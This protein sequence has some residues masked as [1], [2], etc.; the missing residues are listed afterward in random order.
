MKRLALIIFIMLSLFIG[1]SSAIDVPPPPIDID[2]SNSNFEIIDPARFR[3]RQLLAPAYPGEYWVDF[4]WNQN[5]LLFESTNVGEETSSPPGK[6]KIA[7][8]SKS[9]YNYSSPIQAMHDLANWCGTPSESNPCGVKILPG[10]YDIG[11]NTLQMKSYV[12]IEGSGENVTK[13]TGN[14]SSGVVNGAGPAE[15]RL[16]TVEHRGG[17][18]RVIAMNGG[19]SLKMTNI[20]VNAKGGTLSTIGVSY[21]KA[22]STTATPPLKIK[23]ATVTA[24]GLI[25]ERIGV[26]NNYDRGQVII[27]HSVITGATNSIKTGK[28]TFVASTQLNGPVGG[29][30]TATCAGVYDDSFTFYDN[31]CP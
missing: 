10:V 30:G 6:P 18:N 13:I 16:L 28:T 21:Q 26:F 11:A 8:V 23:N 5:Q 12:D 27:E 29:S 2:I 7:I 9:G 15:I 25:N 22:I 31:S 20:T 24:S 1:K 14:S 19:P 3:I 17:V 4:R